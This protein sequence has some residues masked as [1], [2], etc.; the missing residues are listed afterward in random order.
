V[1]A[2]A[3]EALARHGEAVAT[4]RDYQQRTGA[5]RVVVLVDRGDD[6]PPLM[7]DCDDEQSVEITDGDSLA[8]IPG[9]ANAPAAP[10]PLPDIRA[11]PASAIDLDLRT[12][13]LQAPLGAIEHTAQTLQALARAFGNRS[14][15]TAELATR[16]PETTI[17]LAARD[18]EPTVLAAGEY[19]YTLRQHPH[20]E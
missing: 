8:T 19:E 17:T 6:R 12:G 18:N 5:L 14:V 2:A 9:D 7:L 13:D 11:T 16:D 1:D 10:R 15:A 4:V 3:A 20:A